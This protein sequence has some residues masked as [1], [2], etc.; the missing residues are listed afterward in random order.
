MS[1]CER[2]LSDHGL[3]RI[4]DEYGV[5][6]AQARGICSDNVDRPEDLL[7]PCDHRFQEVGDLDRLEEQVVDHYRVVR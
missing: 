6:V 4:N 1:A 7:T 5:V 3:D 2:H